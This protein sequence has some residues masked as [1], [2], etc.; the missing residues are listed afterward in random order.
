MAKITQE[1]NAKGQVGRYS[2]ML[3]PWARL[4]DDDSVFHIGEESYQTARVLAGEKYRR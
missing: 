4:A 1:V 2:L 3:R